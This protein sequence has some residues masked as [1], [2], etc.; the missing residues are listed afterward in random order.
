V[1]PQAVV[2]LRKEKVR[3]P[4]SAIS[5]STR[6]IFICVLPLGRS[7]KPAFGQALHVC[8]G[9]SSRGARQDGGRGASGP[10]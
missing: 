5:G 9:W 8:G 7:K 2:I 3:Q 10:C 4:A 1:I 6:S